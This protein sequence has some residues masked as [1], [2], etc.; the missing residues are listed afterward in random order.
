M[1]IKFKLTLNKTYEIDTDRDWSGD[2]G[3]LIETLRDKID[4]EPGT[5]AS[6]E[7]IHDGI[8]EMLSD[9]FESVLDLDLSEN[10]FQIE[11]P[12]GTEVE[13]PADE[14]DEGE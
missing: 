9:D 7:E 14:E 11:V 5:T 13:I 3:A 12:P 1:G 2:I 6:A 8:R 10:D 4:V